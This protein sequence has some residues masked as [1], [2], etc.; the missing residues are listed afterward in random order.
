MARTPSLILVLVSSAVLVVACG[1]E[2]TPSGQAGPNPTNPNG[3]NPGMPGPRPASPN[4]GVSNPGAPNPGSPIP[5]PQAGQTDFTTEEGPPATGVPGPETVSAPATAPGLPPGARPRI[6]D[7]SALPPGGR[8]GEVEEGNIY[9]V[10]QNRLFYFNT[11]RGFV[12]YDIND[13]KKPQRLGRLPVFGFPV[14]MFVQGNVV[15]ALLRDALYLSQVGDHLQFERH[16]VSQ[17][18]TIDVSDLRNPRLLNATD[19]QGQLKEGVSRKIENTIYV[20]S[21]VSQSFYPGWRPDPSQQKEQATVYSFNVQ[22]PRRPQ[23]VAEYKI[24][25]GGSVSITD[26]QGNSFERRFDSVAISA[27]ANVLM[28]VE[29]WQVSISSQGPPGRPGAPGGCGSFNNSQ[30]ARVSLIDISNPDGQIQLHATFETRGQLT[31]Q[32]KMTYVNEAAGAATFYGIFARQIFETMGCEG[33]SYTTNTLES[34]DV[35]VRGQPRRLDALDFG[36]RDEV[37]RG[38]AYDTTRKVVYAITAQQFDP[39]YAISF[40]DRQNLTVA[41]TID[42]LSGDMSV[43]RLVADNK[44]LLAVGQDASEACEGFQDTE[45]RRP[46]RTAVSLIDVQNLARIRL[47]QRQCVAVKNAEFIG[48]DVSTNLDQAHK[49][50]GMFSDGQVNVLSV[51]IHY[52]KKVESPGDLSWYEWQTAVG[53]MTWD[54]ARYNLQAAPEEQTVIANFGTFVHP[55][56]EV[57]RSVV[58]THQGPRLE[59]MMINLSDSHISIANI[60]NLQNPTLESEIELAPYY[61]Q[62]YRFGDYLVEQVQGKATG[63]GQDRATFRVKRAGGDLD[64]A[65]PVAS[66]D[67]G[68]VYRVLKHDQSLVLLRQKQNMDPGTGVFTLPSTDVL[69]VDMRDPTKPRRA[70]KVLLTTLAT[71]YYRYWAGMGA[72]WGG[73]WFQDAASF[74]ATE[75]G[76]AFHVSEY[77]F[78]GNRSSTVDKLL[79]L[80]VRDP[81]APTVIEQP[82][83]NSYDWGSLGMV[84]DPMAPSGVYISGRKKIGL[85]RGAEGAV[86]TRFKYYA[87]RW[88]PD[89]SG[90]KSSHDIN[91]PGRLIRTW[92]SGAGERMFLSQDT[93][94]RIIEE[95][96]MGEKRWVSDYR[97]SLLRQV[98]VGGQPAAELR[99]ARVL[100]DL[101]PASLLVDG[102]TL[103]VDG[104]QQKNY[105]N[106]FQPGGGPGPV[107]PPTE[108][109][110]VVGTPG[111]P[112]SW[113]VS[114]DRLM[115]FDL[116]ASTLSPIYDKPT[117]MYNME[118]MGIHEGKLFI[119]LPGNGFSESPDGSLGDGILVVDVTNPRAPRGM[120]FLRT[121]GFATHVEFFDQDMYV[122]S[123]YFGLS[124]M[125]ISAPP[126]LPVEAPQP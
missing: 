108:P 47:V 115:I 80:D 15:Y 25:E 71:P 120:Q 91:T 82:L 33:I 125:S 63:S 61:N 121:L 45:D 6:P 76:F 106:G 98:T 48:S 40:A 53:L 41:S 87:Q 77:R 21:S 122:A 117:G 107:F 54:L 109:G 94:Y 62:I 28:V 34:W 105:Y 19:I 90:W 112:P 75:R 38:S 7:P 59:R 110:V 30:F 111:P 65:A 89:G 86:Y 9:K 72:Y 36:K 85:T 23:Q 32:F 92:K 35:S 97:L 69:V 44:F 17:L 24:F 95:E 103:L 113:E 18:V 79:F 68:R 118:L 66:F 102:D 8:M 84:A 1:E 4:P 29:N 96:E 93:S 55:H 39:L 26:S 99:D 31:D 27:T 22:D 123:G 52:T 43:F 70:G 83:L 88:E 119:N 14:E 124:H 56:G 78:E 57:K 42:E 74:A 101:R 64:I 11:Y 12:I 13:P 49:L 81:D 114:S 46:T 51:P 10:D 5:A 100:T 104:R 67:V 37:V 73:F 2:K 20:V 50:L 60:E 116:E 3:P 126:S 16:N 58:F